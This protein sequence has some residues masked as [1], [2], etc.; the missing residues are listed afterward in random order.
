MSPH[1][2][3]P[4]IDVGVLE[5]NRN[6]EN[7]HAEVEQ[8]AFGFASY[9]PATGSQVLDIWCGGLP[10]GTAGWQDQDAI[11]G[12]NTNIFGELQGLNRIVTL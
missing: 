3:Y 2:D 4:L 6:P 11:Q 5:L 10:G 7:Y 1:E 12:M 9:G 8:S